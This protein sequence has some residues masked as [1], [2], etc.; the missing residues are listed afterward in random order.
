VDR[1]FARDVAKHID[2]RRVRRRLTLWT[3]LLAL[4]AAAAAYLRCGG[5]LGLGPGG[6]AGDGGEAGERRP[7]TSPAR[8]AIRLTARGVT[9]AGKAMSTDDAVAAC[10]SS[11]GVT[12]VVTGDA[13][14][15]DREAL[16]A[17]LK[18]AHIKD[19]QIREP[20]SPDPPAQ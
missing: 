3:A 18:A 9:V 12:V 15:G 14:H 17:A 6:D 19:I 7:V 5:G 16:V 8:C 2:R 11:S 4:I 1:Q 20:T 10:K 13:R